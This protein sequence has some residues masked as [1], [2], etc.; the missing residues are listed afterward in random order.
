MK[1]IRNSMAY[2]QTLGA[3]GGRHSEQRGLKANSSNDYR[4]W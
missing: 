1:Y 4:E 3:S 2:T